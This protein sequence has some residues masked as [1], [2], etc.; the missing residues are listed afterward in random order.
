M[1]KY[2]LPIMFTNVLQLFYNS[3]DMFV[4]GNFCADENALGSV[5]CTGSLINMILGIFIGLGAGVS[6][7]LAQSL[8]A[9]NKER[10]SRIVHTAFCLAI[11]LGAVVTLIG[12]IIAVPLLHLMNTPSEFIDGAT[13]YVKIYFWGSIGNIT[14]NFFSGILRSRGDTVRPLIFSMVGGV[15]NIILN[16]VSVVG[17]GMGVE[18]V[19]IATIVSQLI[20]AILV[21]IHMTRLKDE[22]RLDFKKLGIDRS[23]L[24]QLIKVGLP[25]GIQGSLFS[26]SNMLLQSGYNSLGPI[27]VNAN[28]AAMNVDSYIYNILNSFYHTCLTFCSQNFGARKFGRMKKVCFCGAGIV[29]VLGIVLGVAAYVFADPLISIFNKNPE[30]IEIARY[31]LMIVGLPYFLCGLMDVGSALLRSIGYSLNSLLVTFFGSCVFRI[32]WVYTVFQAYHEITVLY[33][34]FPI[35]W[36]ITSFT[37]YLMFFICYKREKRLREI[38]LQ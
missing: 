13:L 38:N 29:T 11:F 10:S 34:V 30:V 37:L 6:V 35:S 23:V 14:Y 33:L 3:A 21:I 31:R 18:G 36:F 5:G 32:V 1:I 25:A 15:I 24:I 4:V 17:F 26:V 20:S 28:V 12:N 7:A 22:C 16:L 2:A 8:G 9:G 27:A 19:A